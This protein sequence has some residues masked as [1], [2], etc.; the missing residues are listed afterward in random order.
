MS[1]HRFFKQKSYM[2][3]DVFFFFFR[4]TTLTTLKLMQNTQKAFIQIFLHLSILKLLPLDYCMSLQILFDKKSLWIVLSV[5]KQ[6]NFFFIC[7][8]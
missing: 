5:V 6:F 4:N 3:A 7:Y 8:V 2:F 1:V